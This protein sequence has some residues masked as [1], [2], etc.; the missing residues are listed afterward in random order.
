MCLFGCRDLKSSTSTSSSDLIP[1]AAFRTHITKHADLNST[2][3]FTFLQC[4]QLADRSYPELP[5]VLDSS[6]YKKPLSF[7]RACAKRYNPLQTVFSPSRVTQDS[8]G[9]WIPRCG[10]LIF[11]ALD[12]RFFVS[13]TWIPDSNR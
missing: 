7:F 11:Q 9:F 5:S 4:P 6:W 8:L 2:L 1:P 10:I 3:S 13:G 12:Y